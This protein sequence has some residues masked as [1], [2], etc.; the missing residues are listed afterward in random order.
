M[1]K[2]R[3]DSGII[4]GTA[5]EIVA[6]LREEIY[7]KRLLPEG[8]HQD[9]NNY[10]DHTCSNVWRLYGIGIDTTGGT[11]EERARKLLEGMHQAELIKIENG[12]EEN[13]DDQE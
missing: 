3:T 5:A 4:K 11:T 6:Q 2:I 10:I 7:D 9:L 8:A 1:K 13:G 12:K